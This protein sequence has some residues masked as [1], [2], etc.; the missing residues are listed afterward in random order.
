MKVKDILD[1]APNSIIILLEDESTEEFTVFHGEAYH[2]HG[3]Y[4]HATVEWMRP[5]ENGIALKVCKKK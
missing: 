2:L 3:E 4:L 1:I 5:I